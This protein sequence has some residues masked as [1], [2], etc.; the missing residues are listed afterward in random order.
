FSSSLYQCF[1]QRCAL[2][3]GEGRASV[4]FDIL[5]HTSPAH[6]NSG[7]EDRTRCGT[8]AVRSPLPAGHPTLHGTSW[9]PTT[10]VHSRA[11]ALRSHGRHIA[12]LPKKL[13]QERCQRASHRRLVVDGRH[14][15]LLVLR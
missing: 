6:T 7:S 13:L 9:P 1:G 11:T 8:H 4:Q 2:Q 15:E 14:E 5:S 3:K 10:T 12:V